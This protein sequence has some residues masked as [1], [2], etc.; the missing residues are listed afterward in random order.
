MGGNKKPFFRV[1]A[2]DSRRPNAGRFL[3]ALGWYDPKKKGTN[4]ELKVDRVEYWVGKGAQLSDTVNSFM[5]KLRKTAARAAA[6][7]APAAAE[8]VAPAA[9]A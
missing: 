5:R 4:F 2:T 7:T 3:E 9:Q 6:K 1:V 8:P